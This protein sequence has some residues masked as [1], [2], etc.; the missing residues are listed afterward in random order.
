MSYGECVF[1]YMVI[2]EAD[3]EDGD[4]RENLTLN[5]SITLY[6]LSPGISYTVTVH[7]MAGACHTNKSAGKKFAVALNGEFMTKHNRNY[8]HKKVQKYVCDSQGFIQ[9][10]LVGGRSCF[11]G[12]RDSRLPLPLYETLLVDWKIVV[13]SV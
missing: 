5:T 13:F 8:G 2:V 10:F 6:G 11:V 1:K 9:D 3:V 7:T 4:R 12:E